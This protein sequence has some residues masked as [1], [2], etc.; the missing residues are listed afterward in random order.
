MKPRRDWLTI[1]GDETETW[2][3]PPKWLFVANFPAQFGRVIQLE[4]RR[5]RVVAVSE[6]GEVMI[7]PI[8]KGNTA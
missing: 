8:G 1:P 2:N 5:G 3:A 4:E 7:L 6:T